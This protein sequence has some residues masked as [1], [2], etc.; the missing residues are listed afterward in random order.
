VVVFLPDALPLELSGS[1]R[2][3]V[4]PDLALALTVDELFSWLKR[5]ES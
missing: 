4:L 2:L 1:D 3:P 5:R